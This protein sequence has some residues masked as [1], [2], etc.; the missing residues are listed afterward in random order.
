M[1]QLQPSACIFDLDGVIVDTAVYHF[2]AWRRLAN[3]L[4][5]DFTEHQNEQ[6][7]GISRMESLDKILAWGQVQLSAEEKNKWAAAKNE[8][9]LSYVRQMPADEILPGVRPF[10]QTL[11]AEGIRIA[12]GSASKNAVLCLER[13]EAIEL[14]DVIVDGNM[15]SR[16]KPDPEV[17]LMAASRLDVSPAHC[18]VFEDAVAGVQAAKRGGMKAVGVGSAEVLTEADWVIGSFLEMNLEKLR[19]LFL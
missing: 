10:L 16:S 3:E 17:F 8:W 18:V 5:F 7:K 6:L 2:K 1:G 12:L 4:G 14:F 15:T 11:K 19:G 13:I 9:Y